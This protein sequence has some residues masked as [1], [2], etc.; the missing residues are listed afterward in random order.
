[1]ISRPGSLILAVIF[2][3]MLAAL[4]GALAFDTVVLYPNI[5]NDVPSSLERAM[6]FLKSSSPRTFFAPAGSSILVI[7]IATVIIWRKHKIYFKFCLSA[8]LLI[9]TGEFLLSA[10]FFWPLNTIMFSEG[11]ALHSQSELVEVASKFQAM[12]WIR[13]FVIFVSSVIAMIGFVVLKQNDEKTNTT[14]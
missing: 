12:H 2:T 7:G 13:L 10:F 1:M 9:V 14:H 6:E 11:L 4:F 5:F 3:W 8:S